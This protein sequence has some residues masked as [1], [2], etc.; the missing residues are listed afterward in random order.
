MDLKVKGLEMEKDEVLVT[1][2]GETANYVNLAAFLQNLTDPE[3]GGALFE[4]AALTS[5]NLNTSKGTAEFV[6]EATMLKDGIKQALIAEEES[7]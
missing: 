1:I 7:E 3:K 2:N 5:V 6:I 4:G